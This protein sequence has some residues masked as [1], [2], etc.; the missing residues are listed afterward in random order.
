MRRKHVALVLC[1]II[2]GFGK[3]VFA[4][5]NQDRAIIN[6]IKADDTISLRAYINEIDD[7]N[8]YTIREHSLLFHSIKY[9]SNFSTK[10]LLR[11]GADPNILINGYPALFWAIRYDTWRIARMLI[12]FG[13]NVN[14][15]DPKGKSLLIHAAKYD[16]LDICK[17]MIDRGADL[18]YKTKKGKTAIDYSLF[19]DPL[20]IKDYMESVKL[21]IEL[22][23]TVASMEDG[24]YFYW[25][26][27][28][29]VVQV[30]Y[31]RIKE[32]NFTRLYE[33]TYDVR[34]QVV[35][36]EG[37]GGDDGVY[38]IQP[39]YQTS[40]ANLNTKGKILALGDV[41]GQYKSLRKLLIRNQVI[42]S[43]DNWLFGDGHLVF[44][45]D[46]FD[47]G[48]KVTETLWFIHELE[49]KAH[50]AGGDIHLLIG[51]HEV[52][53]L[54]G[55]HRYLHPKYIYFSK[56]FYTYYNIFY[57]ENTEMGRWLR[58]QNA[59]ITINGILFL[60]AGISPALAARN[61]PYDSING[62]IRHYLSDKNTP[63]KGSLEE[64]VTGSSGPLWYRGYVE[65]PGQ[66]IEIT[67]AFIDEYLKINN[68]KRMVVGH[69]E[70]YSIQS[71]FEGKVMAIDVPFDRRGVVPQGLLIEGNQL[72]RCYSNGKKE[73]IITTHED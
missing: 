34:N 40:P 48:E 6:A 17:I 38:H 4:I 52:M 27:D 65:F 20:Y 47:R 37:I 54:T 28:S 72:Y 43:V 32:Q 57:G 8:T 66:A 29:E 62:L 15:I 44:L 69:N 35:K 31:R 58:S 70:Q 51:N 24:P 42:D 26:N 18:Y 7:I 50:K 1:L 5:D 21:Q 67:Q 3:F 63:P 14:Y 11:E 12:E 23:D 39:R 60:H 56:Y 25:E 55:D 53:A 36:V 2:S 49:I 30:Q 61:V 59:I 46:V 45:G 19:H 68:L 33:R 64:F 22:Q 71:L 13:A 41:H 9:E 16:R 10:I 73:L